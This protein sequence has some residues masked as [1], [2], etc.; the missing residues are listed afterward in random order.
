MNPK[1]IRSACRRNTVCVVVTLVSTSALAVQIPGYRGDS[2]VRQVL[3]DENEVVQIATQRGAG[4]EIVLGAGEH[5]ERVGMGDSG[6]AEGCGRA[7]VDRA[8]GVDAPVPDWKI[9]ACRGD[10]DIFLKPGS[11]A[12][13]TN[14]IVHTDRHDYAFDLVVLPATRAGNEGVMYRVTFSYR[15]EVAARDAAR[16]EASLIAQ[17]EAA[18]AARRN[19]AYTM[20]TVPGSDDIVPSA[21]WDDGRFTYIEIPGNRKIPSVFRFG[22][23]GSEHVPDR[24]MDGDRIVLHEVAR[25][26]VL[27]LGSEAVELWNNAY[28]LDGVPPVDGT[29]VP[30]VIRTLKTPSLQT[31]PAT[32]GG[33]DE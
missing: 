32:H 22:E 20:Q 17:R 31:V 29:T 24:H 21:M 30:G 9:S 23:D 1:P 7:P 13:N 19:L 5:I 10:S 12:H 4:T 11:H 18:P 26:W 2:R 15:D 33:R 14:L 6:E 27:R 8:G 16:T 3:Y 25:R 28:D